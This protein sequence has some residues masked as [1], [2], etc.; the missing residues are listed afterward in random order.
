MPNKH[1]SFI[2]AL[3]GQ[4]SGGV[5]DAENG[6]TGAFGLG[7]II[8][9]N[10]NPWAAEAGI[11]GASQ[12]PENQMRVIR[13][14]IDQYHQ[15]F[16]GDYRKVAIAWYAGPGAVDNPQYNYERKQGN[17]DE[18]SIN[19]YA[20]SVLGKMRGSS[21]SPV[22]D[23]GKNA[24]GARPSQIEQKPMEEPA[25]FLKKAKD[26]IADGWLDS[27]VGGVYTKRSA[28]GES[29]ATA[30]EQHSFQ[31]TQED[32]DLVTKALPGDY[33]AQKFVLLN[34]GSKENLAVLIQKKR[35]DQ[36]RASR[37]E[38]YGTHW[39]IGGGISGALGDPLTYVPFVNGAYRGY[40][41]GGKIMTRLGGYAP[42]VQK[43][44]KVGTG[45]AGTF[46]GYGGLAVADRYMSEQS[47]GYSQDYT[48]AFFMG[49]ALGTLAPAAVNG[50]KRLAF[51]NKGAARV[52]GALDNAEQHAVAQAMDGQLP[53]ARAVS[54]ERAKGMTDVSFVDKMKGS[55]KYLKELSD[56]GKVFAVTSKQA[57]ELGVLLKQ[58]IKKGVKA[59][60]NA[61]EDYTVLITDNLK[62]GESIDNLLAHE[63]G[64]HGGL[65]KN[66]GDKVYEEIKDSVL[67]KM[68]KPTKEWQDAMRS[69]PEGGWEEVLGHYMEK[70]SLKDPITKQLLSNT[71]KG[72][73]KLGYSGALTEG[74]LKSFV[75]QSLEKEME[76]ARGYTLNSDG[77]AVVNGLQYSA[78]NLFHPNMIEDQITLH[79]S[80]ET[81]KELGWFKN[82]GKAMEANKFFGTIHGT[83]SNSKSP[84][85][86]KLT[87]SLF[88]DARMRDYSGQLVMPVEDM[89]THI[90]D[91]LQSH[92]AGYQDYRNEVLFGDIGQKLQN[93]MNHRQVMSEYN[94]QVMECYNSTYSTNRAGLQTKDF[95]T[96]IREGA[97]IIKNL[98]YDIVEHG[99]QSSNMFGTQGNNLIDAD[100]MPLD[101]ELWRLVDDD[102]WLTFQNKFDTPKS[103]QNFLADYG[104]R[105]AKRDILE[106]KLI[107]EKNVEALTA[108][109]KSGKITEKPKALTEIA[110]EDLEAYIEKE[111]SDW[112]FGITDRDVSDLNFKDS[113]S[114]DQSSLFKERFPM[115][116]SMILHTPTGEAFSF[117]ATLRDMSL[118]RIMKRTVDRFSG[119][120]ALK[121]LFQTPED[122][123]KA[124]AK[125][126]SDLQRGVD[127]QQVTKSQMQ[128]ELNAF[129]EGIRQIRSIGSPDDV[130][131]SLDAFAS[132]FT[133]LSYAQNG[134]NMG[135][136]Q[137][138]EVGG[139]IAYS[140]GGALKHIFPAIP[141]YMNQ[142]R[143]GVEG[144]EAIHLAEKR[145][146]GESLENRIWS[147]V[148]S[149]ES[150]AFKEAS[151]LG[152]HIRQ[153][154]KVGTA[155][156]YTN[157]L[158]SFINRL[159]Q[160]TDRMVR[161]ARADILVDT[162]EWAAGK[163]VKSWRRNPFSDGKLKAAG[164]SG[165]MIQKVKDD[166]LQ[167]T[168]RNSEGKIT[169][170]DAARWEK[171]N[172][173]TFFKWKFLVDNHSKR[174]IQQK[175]VGNKN[176]LKDANGFTRMFFQFKDFTLKAVNG[177]TMR[178][179]THRER[180]DALAA[181]YSMGTNM[182]VYAGVTHARAWAY[183]GEDE[184]K[185]EAYLKDRM[186]WDSLARAAL[187]RGVITGSALSFGND[188]YEAATGAQSVRTTVDRTSS[189]GKQSDGSIGETA[190]RMI[191]QLPALRAATSVLY[192]IPSA[193]YKAL[194]SDDRLVQR[195]YQKLFK[196]LPLQNWIPSVWI[197]NEFLEQQN[198]PKK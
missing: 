88:S 127:H 2:S 32:V 158:T 136:N 115:D 93:G 42:T 61:A 31:V 131:G 169:D 182:M 113:G 64:I 144:A 25:S 166:L 123:S 91:R 38:A 125:M 3:I 190:G 73:R 133:R 194:V 11:A 174:A 28:V 59:F 132:L 110:K 75:K 15:Q 49:G 76:R 165:D 111:A 10:W 24:F 189:Y 137:L 60:Y 151:I 47:S 13:H 74:E 30:Q 192:D 1:D 118:D 198:I 104:K 18:P 124:R 129:D 160:L 56:G 172:P 70:T 155:L 65:K 82:I 36:E 173:D 41:I 188:V 50:I 34:A 21:F 142:L 19:E 53:S 184:G 63:V 197:L 86:R 39:Q 161:G 58:P 4:E 9:D 84:F 45:V 72:L 139:A 148:S 167:Y 170:F 48:S 102:K 81:Q 23:Q 178:A 185:R 40:S 105:A 97:K 77:S 100:W 94:Q 71:A 196:S 54:Y 107:K 157:K 130:K 98:R 159:P 119:E 57:D 35:E 143:H 26:S 145:V 51:G 52:V 68:E 121:N 183:F 43:M 179:L 27:W 120:A 29:G 149:Y 92:I 5:P 175:T 164:I 152:S 78:E 171:E 7:Q 66:L 135:L 117:D 168:K 67:K 140:G 79:P 108:W 6:R 80:K 90:K 156:N 153:F 126:Q 181:I 122:L 176:I 33:S 138:G 112:A 141:K 95:P 96:H 83:L 163:E 154:D 87:S 8:P 195:D 12:T 69:V 55:S 177:Q 101:D 44:V 14:K 22:W 106:Q 146:F 150:R 46:T 85:V 162:L 147:D 187:L 180:D 89:K 114:H 186:S 99:K 103:A 128:R 191:S 17:G 16:G 109:E 116:T 134:A 193:A 37:V 20:D 62:K